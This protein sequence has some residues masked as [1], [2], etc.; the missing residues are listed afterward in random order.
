MKIIAVAITILSVVAKVTADTVNVESEN[1]PF[2]LKLSESNSENVIAVV[3]Y[4]E[5]GDESKE[6]DVPCTMKSSTNAASNDKYVGPESMTCQC[7]A[8]RRGCGWGSS[9]S[10]SHTKVINNSKCQLQV[11]FHFEHDVN[12]TITSV[13]FN[14]D[15][16]NST[17]GEI[18][19]VPFYPQKDRDGNIV[20][21]EVSANEVAQ[22][23]PSM[24]QAA[25]SLLLWIV[26]I[27]GSVIL[28]VALV[29]V[30]QHGVR[31]TLSKTTATSTSTSSSSG[32]NP[33]NVKNMADLENPPQNHRR[34]AMSRH[35]NNDD[36][37][38]ATDD[39]SSDN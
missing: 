28:L 31:R 11:P 23:S 26:I 7:E 22:D 10:S 2:Y 9:S 39:S 4:G 8:I 14:K 1:I 3:Y 30:I 36:D 15:S 18:L 6:I 37:D 17:G 29:R 33:M 32:I 21:V 20:A 5:M 34:T 35:N 12:G 25:I 24:T 27:F 13:T 16:T 38:T 19:I